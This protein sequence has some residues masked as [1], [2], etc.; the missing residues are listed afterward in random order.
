MN[1][2]VC[3]TRAILA[4]A[5]IVML[6]A[7]GLLAEDEE[8]DTGWKDT[9]EFSYVVTA[10][11][12]ETSTFGFKNTLSRAWDRSSMTFKAGGIRAESTTIRNLIAVGSDE[13]FDVDFDEETNTT[14]E[15]Y[16]LSGRYDHKVSDRFFWFTGAG[17]DR[18]RPAGIENRYIA[19]GGVGNIWIDEDRIKFKTD[20]SLSY[21]DQEDVVEVEGVDAS[22]L[23]ASFSWAYL[24]KFGANTTYENFL[25]L[26]ANLEE[27]S[28]WRGDMV[29]SVAVAM[30]SR[31]ALKLSLQWLYD[32]SPSFQEVGR[33]DVAPI[34]PPFPDPDGFVLVELDDLDTVF[35]ASLVVNF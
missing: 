13:D 7:P 1:H 24:H 15:N 27:S 28:D 17:W 25:V 34:G 14:A 33:Y 35:T 29:N 18:N 31:L 26:D 9:A 3:R 4:C 32:N 19:R 12:S 20:Y 6:L 2:S 22:F 5:A 30:N 8:K 11:N 16:F 23:G 10:G 21:T